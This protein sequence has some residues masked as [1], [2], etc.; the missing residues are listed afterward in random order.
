MGL[1][2]LPD[3]VRK[4]VLR[5]IV[6]QL[7]NDPILS[8]ALKVILAWEGKPGDDRPLTIAMAP[9]IR[10]TPT[11]GPEMWAFPD[12]TRG[13][14]FLAVEMIVPGYD[15]GDMIDLWWA[16]ETA[17]YPRDSS[18]LAFQKD[19]REVG[20]DQGLAGAYTGLIEF[21]QPIADDAPADQFMAAVGQMKIEMLLNLNTCGGF[22]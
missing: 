21:S 14:M 2:N 17:L 11:F 8:R 3:S 7:R 1:F 5:R 13:W 19:L 18:R 12:A 4:L 9:G 20:L 15:V 16:I 10:I 6:Q 22:R